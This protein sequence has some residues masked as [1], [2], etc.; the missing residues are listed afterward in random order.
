MSVI[1]FNR[2]LIETQ[3]EVLINISGRYELGYFYDHPS[4]HCVAFSP[5]N[6]GNCYLVG[7]PNGLLIYELP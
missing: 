4:A 6:S 5:K 7:E 2:S 1:P 3:K